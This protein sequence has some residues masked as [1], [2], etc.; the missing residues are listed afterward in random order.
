MTVIASTTAAS[1]AE[2]CSHDSTATCGI[3]LSDPMPLTGDGLR[4]LARRGGLPNGAYENALQI[5]GLRP[6]GRDWAV[7]WLRILLTAGLLFGVAGV[8]CFFAFNWAS[9]S[10][11]L[12]F[13]IIIALMLVTGGLALWRG[14]DSLSG[15]LGLL[16]CGLLAGPLLAVYGQYYQT[17]ADAWELFRAWTVFPVLLALVGRQ[18]GLWL[19]TWIVGGF[20]AALGL[21]DIVLSNNYQ[22]IINFSGLG[23]WD[24]LS[25]CPFL[26]IQ[27][28]ALTI[29]EG[30]IYLARN[31]GGGFLRVS[32]PVRLVGC[33]VLALLTI[34]NMVSII[35]LAN[36]YYDDEFLPGMPFAGA[37]MYIV[38]VG[39][40]FWWYR[41]QRP[42][43]LLLTLILFSLIVLFYTFVLS[44]LD[45]WSAAGMLVMALLLIGL[46]FGATRLALYWHRTALRRCPKSSDDKAEAKPWQTLLFLRHVTWPQLQAR[47]GLDDDAAATALHDNLSHLEPWYIKLMLSVC[48]WVAAIFLITF[49]GFLIF[50]SFG[51]R[52]EAEAF[53]V[54]GA[55]FIVAGVFLVRSSL[56]FVRHF[57]LVV[58]LAGA[59]VLPAALVVSFEMESFWQFP[60]LFTAI[61]CLF[62][63]R[64][65]AMR[66]LAFFA[67]FMSIA[68]LWLVLYAAVMATTGW[69][70]VAY[71]IG[72]LIGVAALSVVICIALKLWAR[73]GGWVQKPFRDDFIRPVI[74]TGMVAVLGFLGLYAAFFSGYSWHR[75]LWVWDIYHRAVY[76]TIFAKWAGL[77]AGVGLIF[78]VRLWF[79]TS[80]AINR[81]HKYIIYAGAMLSVF[82]AWW[83]PWLTIGLLLLALGRYIGNLA[84]VGLS[85]FYLVVC[86]LW[87]YFTLEISL[88]YKAYTLL[89]AGVLML[90][91]GAVVYRLFFAPKKEAAHA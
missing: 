30:A 7:Y 9:M 11:F 55:V 48:G 64:H 39:T 10:H 31:R 85:V 53:G 62:F 46:A 87:Y 90:L 81:A 63:V 15:G 43:T 79:R 6:A 28:L 37:L 17:G 41:R 73:E 54:F 8:I 1:V 78:L 86:L 18:N 14:P 51:Y 35:I 66:A 13:G 38:L 59:L 61:I 80:P 26:L 82:I 60:I 58:A 36:G 83:L 65:R 77:A 91:A 56:V 3:P 75:G 49:M 76:L 2:T 24:V 27:L 52:H 40:G 19:A 4:F 32:W 74:L 34:V 47:L 88:L 57:G 42:D 25:Y 33:F 44:F 67:V 20:W 50:E 68:D 23:V 45:I 69:R 21:Y 89:A 72:E 70:L 16:A 22:Y 84:L 71:F 29:W 5:L 12:K